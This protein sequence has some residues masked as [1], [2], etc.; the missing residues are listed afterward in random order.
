MNVVNLD[1]HRAPA[2]QPTRFLPASIEAEQALLGAILLNNEAFHLTAH[3]AGPEHFSEPLHQNIHSVMRDLIQAGRPA[4]PPGMVAHLGNY[5]IT[6]GKTISSYL[7]DLIREA[8][9]VLGAPEYARI[10]RDTFNRRRL[11]TASQEIIDVAYSA[12]VSAAPEDLAAQGLD[13]IRTIVEE[14]PRKRSRFQMGDGMAALIERVERIRR[15]E[16]KPRGI[17]TGYPDL[18]RATGGLQPGTIVV[19]AARPAMGKTVLMTNLAANVARKGHGVLELSLEIPDDQLQARHLAQVIYD[20]RRP[21]PFGDILRGEID[22]QAVEQIVAAQRDFLRLPLIAECPPS[23]NAAEIAARV[24]V[25]KRKMA[26]NGVELGLVLIDYLDKIAS[27]DR[28]AGQR[29]YEI[30]DVVNVLKSVARSEE[31]CIVLLAQLNRGT[32]GREDKRPSLADIKSSSFLEQEA[33][34]IIFLYREAYYVAKSVAFREDDPATKAHYEQ[35][36]HNVELIIGKNRGGPEMTV[37][38]WGDVSCSIF[39]SQSRDW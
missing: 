4:T 35:V 29:T 31:V 13:S 9:T 26:A 23:M 19:V 12:P 21:V 15:G 3:V 17:S 38:L 7:I 39:S 20:H 37:H 36:E 11:I 25:E 14:A 2:E 6:Q 24:H 22:D 10:I 33:H 30:Q 8:P 27:S 28:Y 34:A 16:E 18:D 1:A 5:E 32:E